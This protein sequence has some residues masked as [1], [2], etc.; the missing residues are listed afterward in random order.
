MEQKYEKSHLA[1]F[2]SISG[3]KQQNL[4][5]VSL[6][7]SKAPNNQLAQP[8]FRLQLDLIIEAIGIWFILKKCL[9][10]V[11]DENSCVFLFLRE[12]QIRD[13][14]RDEHLDASAGGANCNQ[15]ISLRPTEYKTSFSR[16]G[17]CKTV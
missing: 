13:N 2:I 5:C 14:R 12:N 1:T 15:G 16:C 10:H 3:E 8:R 6:N 4:S 17:I 7:S 11:R 9:E